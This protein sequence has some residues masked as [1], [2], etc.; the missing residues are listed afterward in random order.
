MGYYFFGLV[1]LR[2]RGGLAQ[3]N[4]VA[5][6]GY[7]NDLY[8][9]WLTT[10]DL[11][12]HKTDPYTT[13]MEHRIETGLYGRPLDRSNS[14]DAT[15]NYRGF[16]YPLYTD[17]LAAPLA[18]LSF[19]GVQILFSVVLPVMVGLGVACNCAALGL[20]LSRVAMAGLVLVTLFSCQVLAGVYALQPTLIV[21]TLIAAA[22][23]ALRHDKFVLAGVLLALSSVKP[24][25]IVLPMLWLLLWTVT[26]WA[27]RK[28]LLVT[29]VVVVGILLLISEVWLPR[30]WIGWVRALPAYR[31]YT[32]PPLS[33]LL[34]GRAFGRKLTLALLGLG[35]GAAVR[36]RRA[37]A[38]S[39][40]FF[41][42]FA[43]LLAITV[44]AIS[45][46]TA[47]YDQI[48]LLPGALWLWFDRHAILRASRPIRIV[49]YLV[50]LTFVWQW[51]FAPALA[52]AS[53]F[54]SWTHYPPALMFPL[55][56]TG[57][58][59]LGLMSLLHRWQSWPATP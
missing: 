33:E 7:G 27:R 16:S 46:S 17:I 2:S 37:P 56:M 21:A 50:C 5:G 32:M 15:I 57:S 1:V 36:W 6:Y 28:R 14:A 43:F 34:L 51:F 22:L 40:C 18:L 52:V 12:A 44:G 25:L 31:Q 9:I 41:L 13:A 8:P 26:D 24:H 11:L 3:K 38:D 47:V 48:L 58:F 29:F 23:A 59:P 49:A 35:L 39:R 30:W 10:R 42:L 19:R 20:N 53:L 45:S 55:I 54:L 4:M